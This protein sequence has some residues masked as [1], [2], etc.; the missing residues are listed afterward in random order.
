MNVSRFTAVSAD[1]IT[2]GH[3]SNLYSQTVANLPLVI[4]S[5]DKPNMFHSLHSHSN[6][7]QLASFADY[8]FS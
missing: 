2:K 1:L 3:Y 6:Q 7:T 5:V 4:K 8:M